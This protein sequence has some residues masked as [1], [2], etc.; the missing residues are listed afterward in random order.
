MTK[1]TL[2]IVGGVPACARFLA[3]FAWTLSPLFG[4]PLTVPRMLA[5]A[6]WA[7][8]I[9]LWLDMAVSWIL[10]MALLLVWWGRLVQARRRIPE[11]Q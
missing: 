7:L 8:P 9:V 6:S 3:T 2:V 11:G 4:W 1:R 10:P 5:R